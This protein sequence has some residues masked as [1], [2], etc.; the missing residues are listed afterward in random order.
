VS[1]CA[2]CGSAH[3]GGDH[4]HIRFRLPDPLLGRDGWQDGEHVWSDDPDPMRATLLYVPPVGCFVRCLLP[5]HLTGGRTLTYG[6]WLGVPPDSMRRTVEVWHAPE[7]AGL[8]LDGLLANA[9]P[10]WGLLTAPARA[11]VRDPDATP[12]VS[13]SADPAL[14]RVLADEWSDEALDGGA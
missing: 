13:E 10:P 5:I 2:V 9:V 6:V 11:V 1:R 4:R 7:Y 8:V 14:A 12:Y 3:V